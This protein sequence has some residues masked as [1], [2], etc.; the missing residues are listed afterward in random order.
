MDMQSV[1]ELLVANYNILSNIK[2]KVFS[3]KT[4]FDNKVTLLLI[5]V[6]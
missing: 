3:W 5:K 6:L 1:Y 4:K 2:R